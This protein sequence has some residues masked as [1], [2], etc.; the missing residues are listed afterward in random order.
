MGEAEPPAGG[1][2]LRILYIEDNPAD[3]ELCQRCLEKAGLHFR[4]DVVETREEFQE[5]LAARSYDLILADYRLPGWNGMDAFH[6]LRQAQP[7]T[8]FILVTGSLGEENA[9]EYLQEGVTDYVLKDRLSRLPVA[10]ARALAEKQLKAERARGEEAMARL[11]A[12]VESSDDAII[13]ADLEGRILSWNPAA[14]RLFGPCAEEA[15]GRSVA[16]VVPAGLG[17]G[18]VDEVLAKVRGGDSVHLHEAGPVWR[19]DRLLYLSLNLT[20]VR[21]PQGAV[22]GMAVMGRDETRRRLLEDQLRLKNRALAD[23]NR[24][25][26]AANRMKNGFLAGMSHE[27]R[28]PLNSVIGLAELMH[29]GKLG[30]VSVQHQEY[31][32]D[33]LH[34]SRHLLRLINDVLDLSRV[35]AGCLDFRAEP[36]ALDRL[37]NEASHVLR[38]SAL[39]KR[40]SLE[41]EISP[42]VGQIITDAGRLKQILYNYLSNA[43]KFTP[44]GGRVMVRVR[45]EGPHWFRLEVEDNGI[46]IRAED[47]P[48]L[49]HEFQQL[50]AG[51]AA[52][53]GGSG[54]GLALTKRIVEAQ[55]GEVGVRSVPGQGSAFSAVLPRVTRDGVVVV[56]ATGPSIL[57]VEGAEA[58]AAWLARTLSRAGYSMETAASGADAASRC[59][60][61]GFAGVAVNLLL[62]DMTGWE[63]LRGIRETE[64]NHDTP[65]ILMGVNGQEEAAC[66]FGIHDFLCRP[67]DAGVLSEAVRG[68]S[69][70]NRGAPTVLVVD[71]DQEALREAE[72]AL[73][74]QGCRVM[75]RDSLLAGLAAAAEHKPDVVLVGLL[76]RDLEDLR[77]LRRFPRPARERPSRLIAWA[78][79]DLFEDQRER[80]NLMAQR[81]VRRSRKGAA[82]LLGELAAAL[83]LRPDSSH[84]AHVRPGAAR[85]SSWSAAA[86]G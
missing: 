72:A 78:R 83:R 8:P 70:R 18:N 44:E 1:D 7:E 16:A 19:R 74:G 65:V 33:I 73:C 54:L 29:D 60:T 13:G 57:V 23:Q 25:V 38:L 63:V 81:L 58:G 11:A 76:M 42:E 80:L 43:V 75:G 68:S 32:D 86:S 85:A 46:G 67:V 82:S 28:T 24:R 4:M 64:A 49:F 31:L 14:S 30:P 41:T 62:N 9:V 2:A 45:P 77:G 5:R 61:R 50:D 51:L 40:I 66:A 15:V 71:D 55:G 52:K 22:V 10:V 34:S 56:S 26:Q 69:L 36:V 27:L 39:K 48:R 84:V 20:P 37:V 53:H 6:L 3:V 17:P 21:N 59:Q 47:L 79:R 35:E 12:I